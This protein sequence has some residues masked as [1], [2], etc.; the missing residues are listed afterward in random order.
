[1]ARDKEVPAKSDKL[2]IAAPCGSLDNSAVYLTSGLY[3]APISL[4]REAI[5]PLK[6]VNR[7][8][9]LVID[10]RLQTCT[11]AELQEHWLELAFFLQGKKSMLD[12]SLPPTYREAYERVRLEFAKRGV[13]LHLF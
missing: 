4:K 6:A 7:T 12:G 13:Q 1:M 2:V 11:D 3:W 10:R 8:V 5:E 9:A